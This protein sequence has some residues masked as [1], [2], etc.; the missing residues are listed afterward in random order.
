MVNIV[1]SAPGCFQAKYPGTA[2][3][4][5]PCKTGQG[6]P[7]ALPSKALRARS[8]TVG[9]GAGYILRAPT[10]KV[11]QTNGPGQEPTFIAKTVGLFPS[12]KGIVAV[13]SS[14]PGGT[15]PDQYSL[16]INTNILSR[17]AAC[18]PYPDSHCSVGQQFVYLT[19]S[20]SSG[21]LAMQY[22]IA[23]D[24]GSCPAGWKNIGPDCWQL[25]PFTPAPFIPVTQLEK[26]RL[27]AMA[28]KGGMD[29]VRLEYE[30][31]VYDLAAPDSVLDISDVW[32]ESE[33][34]IFGVEDGARA[35]FNP[36][37]SLTVKVG[38][39]YR[40]L[41]QSIYAP[42]CV[43]DAGITDETNNLTVKGPCMAAG[44]SPAADYPYIQFDE[45]N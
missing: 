24:K 32:R 37:S 44:Y 2:L 10:L 29:V 13:V 17:S 39:F 9:A 5:V 8:K 45:S 38:A 40:N 7:L 33:F 15:E 1:P 42:E 22:T 28:T 12:E 4:Q 18:D 11:P 34:N 25:T 27:W 3:E 19:D 6:R 41:Q 43:K 23:K 35:I 21:A 31:N 36:Y 14:G 16:Q 26:V 30:G 20:G